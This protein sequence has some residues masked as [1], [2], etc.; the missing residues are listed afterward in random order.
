MAV[1]KVDYQWTAN[2]SLFARYVFHT[3]HVPAPFVTKN[4]LSTAGAGGG[5]HGDQGRSQ[6]FTLGDTYLIGANI[7][8]SFRLTGNR[9]ATDKLEARSFGFPDVGVKMF[10]Y[11]PYKV[12]VTVTGGF[13]LGSSGGPSKV[14]LFG[15]SDDVTVLTGNHQLAFGAQFAKWWSNSY[16]TMYPSGRAAFNGQTTGMGMADFFMGN[17]SQWEGGTPS[18]Q[19]RVSQGLGL[20]AVD[21]WKVNQKLTLNYGLRWEPF[22]PLTNS[23]G[24][25]TNFDF[26]RF[27]KGVKSKIP[28]RI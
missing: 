5:G 11:A 6:T 18:G 16:S 10:S 27:K 2:H 17:V 25:G 23:D 13:A 4:E 14:A 12:S 1:G 3:I 21:T 26:D 15:V 20:Y 24:T 28:A 9:M 7:V 19:N 22:F 8:N